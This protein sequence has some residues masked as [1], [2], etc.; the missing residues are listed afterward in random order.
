MRTAISDEI[1]TP[2]IAWALTFNDVREN[3]TFYKTN[4][5]KLVFVT[6]MKTNKTF[7]F[8]VDALATQK[9]I[10]K[11]TTVGRYKFSIFV[12]DCLLI[13]MVRIVKKRF[14]VT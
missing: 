2:Q 13:L 4:F 3:Q 11:M 8:L 9:I 7:R 10:Q 12:I 6:F 14:L 1:P 5:N